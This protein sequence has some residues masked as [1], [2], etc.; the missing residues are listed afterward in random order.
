VL[1]VAGC[2][3]QDA[4]PGQRDTVRQ[5]VPAAQEI[6]C[7]RVDA[8]LTRCHAVTGN[9]LVGKRWT[10]ELETDADPGGAAY[11]G[12]QSCWTERG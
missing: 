4:S 9:A 6:S 2:G 1:V 12:S 3:G 5:L 10:C 7:D 11:S 8:T